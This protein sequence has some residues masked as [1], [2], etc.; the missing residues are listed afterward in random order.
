MSDT[1]GRINVAADEDN[2]VVDTLSPQAEA[3]LKEFTAS[4]LFA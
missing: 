1:T 3:R 2:M 4:E